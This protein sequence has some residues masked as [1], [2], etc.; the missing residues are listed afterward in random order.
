MAKVNYVIEEWAL[1]AVLAL[2]L[3]FP[4]H[5]LAFSR[6]IKLENGKKTAPMIQRA[7]SHA[8]YATHLSPA[9]YGGIG[10]L[11]MYPGL[12][13]PDE[14]GRGW[15]YAPFFVADFD[16]AQPLDL[17]PLTDTLEGYG[18]TTYLTC[19][20]TGRG[21]H[22]YGF[23][24]GIVP[25]WQI[26]EVLKGIQMI[27]QDAG[28]GVPEIRPSCKSGRG[29]PIFLPYRGAQEDGYGFNPLLDLA[30][31]MQPLRLEHALGEV[32]RIPTTALEAF[33][34]EVETRAARSRA[35]TQSRVVP[36]QR[37]ETVHTKDGVTYLREE[38]ESVAPYFVEPH[39][40]NLVMALT[41][42]GVRG[43]KLDAQTV[44]IEVTTFIK[45]HD[46]DELKRRLAALERT[47]NK[48][49][50]DPLLVAWKPY[51]LAFGLTPPG[52]LGISKDV[53][54]KLEL[55]VQDLT[56]REWK[57]VS[58]SSDRS[59]FIALLQVAAEH[60]VNHASGV[61]VS[62]SSRDLALRAGVGDKTVSN[63][64]ARLKKSKTVARDTQ[65]ERRTEQAGVLL[66]LTKGVSELPHSFPLLGGLKEWG[67]LY[68]HPAFRHGKLNKS[69]APV[70]VC[71][72]SEARPLTRPELAKLLGRKSRDLRGPLAKLLRHEL[73]IFSDADEAYTFSPSW[74][75]ALER[76]AII[77]GAFRTEE[78]QRTT[79]LAERAAFQAQQKRD[80]PAKEIRE[81]A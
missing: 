8:D 61:A 47:L 57:G 39:R 9:A 11:G 66:I 24:E 30:R 45:E 31:D 59:V 35:A 42:Y 6:L 7:A 4:S 62:V 16:T 50:I 2:E 21:S 33:R 63:S 68:T 67:Q 13:V 14:K 15:W 49:E 56:A 51:Y 12:S 73:V 34:L 44:R 70:L 81:A 54:A 80:K 17:E 38:F 75:K 60:G 32:Q 19:G 41:A 37:S 29:A 1:T 74:Q 72:L 46:A 48:H 3:L 27:S 58:G 23:V 22:L 69:A 52:K 26:Y 5:P 20:T 78:R 65:I 71:L 36:I 25:Q 28:L 77:T 43:L 53:A 79:H 64:L 76:A 10:A 40:Q 18:L 55:A